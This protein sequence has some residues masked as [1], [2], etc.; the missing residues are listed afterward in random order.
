MYL[1]EIVAPRWLFLG[2]F[3]TITA[4]EVT[5]CFSCA[6]RG[7]HRNQK[8]IIQKTQRDISSMEI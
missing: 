3:E 7:Q 1:K 6:E 2:A 8:L 4:V 5:A